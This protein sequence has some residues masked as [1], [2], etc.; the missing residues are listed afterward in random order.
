MDF[1][2]LK[3]VVY[4]LYHYQENFDLHCDVIEN[5]LHHI[6]EIVLIHEIPHFFE[7]IQDLNSNK[8]DL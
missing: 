2:L 7:I 5:I 1:D 8:K 3:S 4:S 6:D